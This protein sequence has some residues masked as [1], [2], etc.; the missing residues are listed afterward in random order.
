MAPGLL[1]NPLGGVDHQQ[2]GVGRRR[3]GHHVAEEL[4]VA[5]GID[6]DIAARVGTKPD[7]R[8][9]DGDTLVALDLQGVHH[10]GPFK[11]G[12]PALGLGPQF[13]DLAVGQA[14]GVV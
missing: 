4:L 3:P 6:D 1:G 14:A 8:G 13:L 10:E 7:A 12:A 11:I 2:R 5:R 9:V